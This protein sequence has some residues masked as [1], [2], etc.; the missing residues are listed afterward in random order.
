MLATLECKDTSLYNFDMFCAERRSNGAS[1]DKGSNHVMEDR[2]QNLE[3]RKSVGF[4]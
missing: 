3:D 1:K 2:T 4:A